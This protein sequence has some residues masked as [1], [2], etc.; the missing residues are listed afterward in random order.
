MKLR[1]YTPS[2]QLPDEIQL[3][4]CTARI[5]SR[6]PEAYTVQYFS[7]TGSFVDQQS[8]GT[9]AGLPATIRSISSC[10]EAL[11]HGQ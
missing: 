5:V 1:T 8:I 10:L 2:P 7:R 4:G 6:G 9:K 11:S 3:C